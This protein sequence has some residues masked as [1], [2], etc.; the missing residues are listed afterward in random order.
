MEFPAMPTLDGIDQRMLRALRANGRISNVELA[1]EVGLSPSACLRRLRTLEQSGVIRGYT[2]LVDDP[3][4]ANEAVV[5]VQITLERQTDDY[6]RR[7]E[8]AARTCPDIRECYLMT[9]MA[10][11]LLRVTI[12][13]IGSY[14][15][16]HKEVLSSLPGVARIQSSFAIRA[17]IKPADLLS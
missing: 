8:K 5:I 4:A 14:E 2:A 17:V 15:R 12:P 1:T 7:F 11:Y 6:L 16:I 10:D 3:T 13:D 9:G